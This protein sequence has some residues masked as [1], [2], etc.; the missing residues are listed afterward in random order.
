MSNKKTDTD[1]F[2]AFK[3]REL[4]LVAK[5]CKTIA[6]ANHLPTS[7]GD[8]LTPRLANALLDAYTAGYARALEVNDALEA[9]SEE[10]EEE[11]AAVCKS[12]N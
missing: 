5:V 10:L 2:G 4:E 6:M 3:Q 8:W 11:A 9:I 1:P 7:P 12:M